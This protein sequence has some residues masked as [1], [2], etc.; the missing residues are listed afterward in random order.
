MAE[1]NNQT[2]ENQ[3]QKPK[4]RRW[5]GLAVI[6][7]ILVALVGVMTWLYIDQKMTTQEI[8]NQLQEEKDSL[9]SELVDIRTEYDSLK[10]TTDTLN[11]KLDFEQERVDNLLSEL[12]TIKATNYRRIKELRDEV[13][14]LRS[15]AKSYVR[16][17]DS[18]NRANEQLMAEN[19]R[20]REEMEEVQ[21][22]KEQLEE[23]KEQLSETVKKASV[24]RTEN[25]KATPINK[26]GNEKERVDKIDK[27]KVCFTLEENVV[28][29]PGDRYVYMRIASPPDDYI[30]TNSE[31]NIFEFEGKKIVYTAR[32]PIEYTG[33]SMD[34]C[35]YF[36]SQGQL[37]P[38]EYDVFIFA[39][40][41]KIGETK[42]KLE[43]S[44]WLFF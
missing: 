31:D 28:V 35:L 43:E 44:G 14:T 27:I 25:L 16:Q 20:V 15:I 19:R 9:Q 32:R 11:K 17:I 26:R 12:K 18:L 40:G 23:E 38:G 4:K 41:H 24:L 5:S 1:N 30:L 39:D 29:E 3:D 42:F 21:E 2:P 34:V 7:I 22:S 6:L 37:N 33:E 8:T 13:S 10:T 36:D